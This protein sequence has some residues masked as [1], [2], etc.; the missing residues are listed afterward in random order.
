MS[1]RPR[2]IEVRPLLVA[3]LAVVLLASALGGCGDDGEDPIKPPANPSP[4]VAST[5]ETALANYVAAYEARDTVAVKEVYDP[6]YTG[7]STDLN[8]GS[9]IDF[10]YD[11]EL[12]HVR[13]LAVTPGLT[14]NLD[15]GPSST[16]I[17]TPSDDP[18]HPEWAVITISGSAYRIE[19]IVGDEVSGAIG[20]PGTFQEFAFSP[21]LDSA[22]PSDTL[23]KI[24][25]WRE[26][27]N[28]SPDMAP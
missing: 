3:L 9:S 7:I 22:S 21:Q 10:T 20:E 15:L 19:V 25:R 5:P 28:S 17:R 8:G 12:L 14:V 4:T 16:W 23:W 24:M 18:S 1:A 26:T 2:S 11:D 13:A 27:G 6:A